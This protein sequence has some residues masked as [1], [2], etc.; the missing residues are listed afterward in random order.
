MDD[1]GRRVTR[2]AALAIATNAALVAGKLVIG[3]HTGSASIL[4]E[5]AHSGVDLVVAV[6]AW[7]AIRYAQ[8]PADA[9]HPYGH[10]K[11]EALTSLGE[12]VLIFIVAAL[13]VSN[14]IRS[15]M[16]GVTVTDIGAGI[17]VMVVA[18]AINLGVSRFLLRVGR[19][20][21]SPALEAT[22][23]ELRTDVL[24][25]A[26]VIVGLV[27]VAATG[28]KI[29]DPL[30]GLIVACFIVAAGVR[31]TIGAIRGLT[32][33]RL[34]DDDE[35]AI[36]DV[37]NDHNAAFIEYHD[38]RSRHVGSKHEVDLHLVVPRDMSVSD[39]H[40]LSSHLEDEIVG[41]LPHTD[42]VIHVEPDDEATMLD[43]AHHTPPPA[44]DARPD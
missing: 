41:A 17:A 21:G 31:V 1:E 24:T 5:A 39:A 10:G 36:R 42:V 13:I 11:V 43:D 27:V 2:A 3:A 16:H 22:G 14:A 33:Y 44:N 4:S 35:R 37:L 23:I 25:A 40:D 8:R 30:V 38:L 7:A 12:S 32:D 28:W 20:V 6:L 29:V 15:L 34:P 18:A 9:T 26:G 19:S